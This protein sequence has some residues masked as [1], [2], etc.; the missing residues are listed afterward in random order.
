MEAT[1]TLFVSHLCGGL[2]G[3]A[4]TLV[5]PIGVRFDL[6]GGNIFVFSAI[7]IVLYP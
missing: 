5:A 1:V 2:A 4:Q 7:A 3:M 6:A